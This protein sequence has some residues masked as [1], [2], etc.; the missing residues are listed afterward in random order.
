MHL[1][2]LQFSPQHPA[3]SSGDFDRVRHLKTERD[4]TDS[5]KLFL[6]NHHFVPGTSYQFPARTFGKQSKRF[7]SNW[8]MA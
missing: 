3:V 4:L 8:L 7:Q 1:A 6:L 2:I 5:E